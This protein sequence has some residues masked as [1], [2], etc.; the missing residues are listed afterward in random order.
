MQ[1][2]KISSN[3]GLNRL[4]G[5][6]KKVDKPVEIFGVPI[7]G[8]RKV[9]VLNKI[10]LQRKE[11]L[12]LTT[13][14]SEYVMEARRNNKFKEILAH[15]WTV[16]DSWGVMWALRLLA[17]AQGKQVERVSGVELV[18]EI[19]KRASGKGEKVFLLGAQPGI[20]EK[21][22]TEMARRYPG[23]R[24]AWF[25]GARTVAVEE[26][27]EASMT[28][29]KINGFEPDYLLV[30]YGSPW[31]DIWIE[32]NRPYLRTR[33]AMGVGGV[34]D[35]WAGVVSICPKWLDQLGLKWGWRV[36]HEPWRW[37]RVLKVLHFG[38][39]VIWKKV[40]SSFA[41]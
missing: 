33:V 16:V 24:Y 38:A 20:A 28:I 40:S 18:E 6:S 34:L 32:E 12:H 35:E 9:E 36:I 11:M 31:Q 41:L 2:T 29:A 10:G 19:L 22:A 13:V 27:E 1:K 30:A 17:V 26:S 3:R 39:L 23:A 5:S 15:T 37:K 14:N 21:A 8:T 7:F 25:E 4:Q